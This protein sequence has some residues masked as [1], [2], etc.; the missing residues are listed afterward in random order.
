MKARPLALAGV[1]S[2][3]VLLTGFGPPPDPDSFTADDYARSVSPLT[4]NVDPLARNVQSVATERT[5]GV[6]DVV[7]LNSDIL[8]VF[9]SAKLSERAAAKIRELITKV[10]R[11]AKV[12]VS[13]HTDSIGSSAYN[14]RLS[15]QRARAVAAVIAAARG[16]L[17][18]D[19]RGYGETRAVAS[20]GSPG[21]D[22]PEGRAKNRRVEL[23]YRI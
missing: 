12:S 10:P 23:R 14:Q 22:N 7:T 16:D 9:N 19:V 1:L 4:R 11:K 5:E 8:F 21:S 17:K 3:A 15:T 2:A 6:D 18:L 13:G 20:N